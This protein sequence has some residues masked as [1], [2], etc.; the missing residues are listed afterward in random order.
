[1]FELD[2][3]LKNDCVVVGDLPLSTV[4]LSDNAQVPWIILVPRVVDITE[5]IDLDG[6]QQQ[7]LWLESAMVSQL[8]RDEFCPD[9][10]NVA[11]IGNMVPQL[12]MHHIA[13]FKTDPCWPAPVWGALPSAPYTEDEKN[14][15]VMLIRRALDAFM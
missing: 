9:K 8:L 4:L 5:I 15:R 2:Q 11:A 3:R 6:Q 13:R 10:L 1:M 7:Q 12:H 14:A